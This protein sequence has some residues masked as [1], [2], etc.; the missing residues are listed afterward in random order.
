MIE[1]FEGEACWMQINRTEDGSYGT[2]SIVKDNRHLF[3]FDEY[4][5]SYESGSLLGLVE[6]T[7][8]RGWAPRKVF[9]ANGGLVPMRFEVSFNQ[10]GQLLFGGLT[11]AIFFLAT[12]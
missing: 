4:E 12:L 1:L 9:V 10:A 3:V 7:S 11:L 5:F 2:M 6:E 8:E